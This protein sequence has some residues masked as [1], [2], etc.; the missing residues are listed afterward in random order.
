MDLH[1]MSHRIRDVWDGGTWRLERVWSWLPDVVKDRIRARKIRLNDNVL[2]GV[3]WSGHVS[4][5]YSTS[6]G[7]VWIVQQRGMVPTE[8]ELSWRWIWKLDVP[9]KCNLLVWLCGHDALP[10]NACRFRRG[11]TDS[12]ECVL[13]HS[14]S[15]TALHCLRDCSLARGIWQRAGFDVD[16]ALFRVDSLWNWLRGLLID[17]SPTAMAT[18]WWIWRVWNGVCLESFRVP[19]HMIENNIVVMAADILR[20]LVPVSDTPRRQ[21]RLVKWLPSLVEGIVLNVDGSVC[22]SL[23]EGGSGVASEIPWV[24]G[25]GGFMAS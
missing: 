12:D 17:A 13:C 5:Q 7:Y 10:T 9:L 19:D 16:G 2:D 22:G 25:K 3:R 14:H 8:H 1:D 18:L 21:P 11:M 20:A 23:A 24:L 6:S 15:E 4:S